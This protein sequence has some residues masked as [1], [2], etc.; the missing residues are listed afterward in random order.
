MASESSEGTHAGLTTKRKW[1]LIACCV[2]VALVVLPP[3]V[4]LLLATG[5][6]AILVA[7]RWPR[8]SRQRRWYRD[9]YLQSAHWRN[10][11][12][13]ALRIHGHRC[14]ECGSPHSLDVHH[15][16]YGNLWREDPARDLQVLCRDCH[17]E[18]H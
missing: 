9:V 5:L 7:R 13:A 2:F 6:G 8:S 3:D 11:R 17:D 16:R 14:A 4:V 18:K 12:H 15:L 1:L 10:T